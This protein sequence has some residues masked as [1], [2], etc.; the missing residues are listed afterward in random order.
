MNLTRVKEE[1]E[2]YKPNPIKVTDPNGHVHTFPS[3]AMAAK[4]RKAAGLE[5][6]IYANS[7]H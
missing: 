4:F 7:A 6:N 5:G 3:K 2:K 1:A